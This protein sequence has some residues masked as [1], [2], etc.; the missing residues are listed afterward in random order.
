MNK[1]EEEVSEI[2]K[3]DIAMEAIFAVGMVVEAALS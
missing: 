2:S 3:G 1:T